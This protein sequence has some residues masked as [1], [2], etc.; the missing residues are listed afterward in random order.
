MKAQCLI[1]FGSNLG[2]RHA[3]VADAAKAVARLPA[4]ADLRASRLFETPPIGGPT[5]QEP[6]LNAVAAFNTEASA[7]KI[8]DCLQTI[9]MDLGRQRRQRWGA[10][11]IASLGL[12]RR[13]LGRCDTRADVRPGGPTGRGAWRSACRRPAPLATVY[14][15]DCRLGADVAV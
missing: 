8:L 9:E 11:A 12:S 15:R 3:L 4:V 5:G 7:R 6:F 14:P 1:S 13:P 2:D 10:R